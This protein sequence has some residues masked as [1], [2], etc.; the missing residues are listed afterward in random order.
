MREN[1]KNLTPRTFPGV[2]RVYSVLAG[3]ATTTAVSLPLPATDNRNRHVQRPV[4]KG[5]SKPA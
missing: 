2:V 1:K 5:E 3:G 4:S